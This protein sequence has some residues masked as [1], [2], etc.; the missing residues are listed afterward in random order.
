M[1]Q[2][3]QLDYH[4]ELLEFTPRFVIQKNPKKCLGIH[5]YVHQFILYIYLSNYFI[6]IINSLYIYIYKKYAVHSTVL[7]YKMKI[8]FN[9]VNT[10]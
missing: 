7:Y 10:T 2:Y 3:A 5:G 4:S 8:T 9:C 1:V 6:I